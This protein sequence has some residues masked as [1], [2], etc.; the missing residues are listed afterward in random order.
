MQRRVPRS[1]TSLHQPRYSRRF[2]RV[3][4]ALLFTG[5]AQLA[6]LQAQQPGPTAPAAEDVQQTYLS[7]MAAF[8]AGDYQK[9]AANLESALAQVTA[10]SNVEPLLL[11]LGAAYFNLKQYPQAVATFKKYLAKYPSGT[12]V[13]DARMSAIQSAFLAKDY[14][15]VA[16]ICQRLK[17]N[18]ATREEATL[19]EGLAYAE[20][21]KPDAAVKTLDALL[22][23]N[24]ATP[25][26]ARAALTLAQLYLEKS[27]LDRLI[28][29]LEKIRDK[30]ELLDNPAKL[31]TIAISAGDSLLKDQ[32]PEKALSCYQTVFTPSEVTVSSQRRI[33]GLQKQLEENL[34][35]IRRTPARNLE[36]VAAN[37]RLNAQI[38]EQESFLVE[39]QKLPDYAPTL[40]IRLAACYYQMHKRWEAIVV[41]EDFLEKWKDDPNRN[42]VIFSLI[43]ASNEVNRL[44]RTR[45]LCQQ[46]L[47]EFPEDSHAATVGYLL[48]GTMLKSNDLPAAETCIET[49]LDQQPASSYREEL[50]FLLTN[51]RCAQRKF[52]QAR[53][54][55]QSYLKDYPKGTH[56][57]ESLYRIALCSL[58]I[59][60]YE[61]AL[62][63]FKEYQIQ[64]P[65]GDFLADARY[66]IALCKYSSSMYDAV[67][68]DCREWEKTFC[69]APSLAE[70]LTLEADA[71]AAKGM[72]EEAVEGYIKSYKAA[73][74]DQVI[75]YAL[76]AA[77]KIL[78][79]KGAWEKLGEMAEEFASLYPGHPCAITALYWVGKAKAHTGHPQEAKTFIAGIV[80]D[81]LDDINCEA[82]E[83]ML[84]QLASLCA[85]KS[86]DPQDPGMEL[87]ALLLDGGTPQNDTAK[88]RLLY[89]KSELARSLRQTDQSEACLDQISS[90][91]KPG[92]LSP[93]LL[94]KVGDLL[95]ENKHAD[96]AVPYFQR[97][98]EAFPKSEYLDFA[99]NGLGQA[100]FERGEYDL[101]LNYF[102]DA[103]EKAGATQKLKEVSIGKARSLLALD[104]LGE[105]KACFEAIV[106]TK[107]W[108][109]EA[110]ALSLYGLGQ[111]AQRQSNWPSAIAYYQRVYV[112]YQRYL[113]WVAKSYLDSGYCFEQL[114]NKD[115]A[116]KTYREATA[117]PKLVS[118]AECNT[119]RERLASLSGEKGL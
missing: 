117:N 30:A 92:D 93:C 100:A 6:L 48:A 34:A 118:F 20:G 74:D 21:K 88:S 106:M 3:A 97:L 54:D 51:L 85:R 114:G 15:T 70:V 28:P 2:P 11:T 109:G 46:Y 5:F 26:A 56:G 7:A 68:E 31:N 108:R 47:N 8:Q 71:L 19:Y 23:A 91:F 1:P 87:E 65:N 101:A 29:L 36:L 115:A 61:S 83:P 78:Q 86:A 89:A 96:K 63:Q 39:F 18:P 73:T 33:A 103:I 58:F 45:E 38:S 27:D 40:A 62:S 94:A 119:A 57:E 16:E 81:H 105:A 80:R 4:V 110:T 67:I 49:I 113:P 69:H 104:R 13:Q 64:Y 59:G 112:A 102:S 79:K 55:Y 41:Y 99:Y 77:Q 32:K 37:A 76:F 90:Q 42:E 44:Q 50:R 66:R 75:Q 43:I 116:L 17:M 52:P 12:R 53:N 111:I 9:A 25:I 35:A 98:W 14:E 82:V 24:I 10:N 60:E 95:M 22:A 84:T 107:E 72:D